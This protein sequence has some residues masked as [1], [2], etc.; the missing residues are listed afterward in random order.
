MLHPHRIQSGVLC[1]SGANPS[2]E[3]EMAGVDGPFC[4]VVKYIYAIQLIY[5]KI[6]D[7]VRLT[8]RVIVRSNGS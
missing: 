3:V 2:R 1:D 6:E 8:D 4:P 5:G 7:M